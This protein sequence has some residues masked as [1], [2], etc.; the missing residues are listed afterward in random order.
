MIQ[1]LKS[2]LETT[3]SVAF[4]KKQNVIFFA[5]TNIRIGKRK[6]LHVI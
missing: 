6:I 3:G 2:G 5:I 1:I 4:N